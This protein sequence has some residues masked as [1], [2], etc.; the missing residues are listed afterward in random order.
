MEEAS[1]STLEVKNDQLPLSPRKAVSPISISHPI[2]SS[3]TL[4]FSFSFLCSSR[5]LGQL[6]LFALL[7]A[8]MYY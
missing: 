6:S 4:P 2:W 7:W 3:I 1:T 8:E 5:D